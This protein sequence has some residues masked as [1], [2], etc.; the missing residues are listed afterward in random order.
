MKQENNLL[1]VSIIAVFFIVILQ[2]MT[3]LAELG[4]K[5]KLE[6][7]NK[8]V[9]ALQEKIESLHAQPADKA[10]PRPVATTPQPTEPT[11]WLNRGKS[12]VLSPDP[13]FQTLP[14]VK[15]RDQTLICRI[16]ADE[17]GF[18][19]I[20]ESSAEILNWHNYYVNDFLAH[21]H[22]EDP[23]KWAAHLA[24][25][26]KV[27]EDNRE[28]TIYLRRDVKWHKPQVD[29][30]DARYD[31]LKGDHYVTSHDFYFAYTTIINPQVQA[32]HLRPY[33]E[34]IESF[35]I[36]DDYTFTI[37]WKKSLYTNIS[38]TMEQFPLAKFL[39]A[40]D[41]NG[42][43]FNSSTFGLEFNRH[44]YNDGMMGCGPYIFVGQKAGQY[45]AL[46]RNEEYYGYKPV[47]QRLH[48]A[49]VTDDNTSYLKLKGQEI[50]VVPLLQENVY[51]DD[52]Y[53]GNASSPFKQGKLVEQVYPRL[54]YY[55]IDWNNA[56][57]IFR[58]K[59]VRRA[60]TYAFD[61]ERVLKN[62]CMG[63]GTI[64]PG[65]IP[66]N[67]L[68]YNKRITP[69]P[70]DLKVA[71]KILEDAGW[72][73]DNGDGILEKVI[74]GERRKFEF[75]LFYVGSIDIYRQM[76]GIYRDSLLKIGVRMNPQGADWPVIQQ[77]YGD[78]DFDAIHG[79]WSSDYPLDFYQIW[80][81]KF[82]D[83]A[84]SSN[85]IRFKNDEVDE[86]CQKMREAVD[87][88]E[89]IKLA[90]RMQEIWHDEQP[91]TFLFFR[92]GVAAYTNNVQNRFIRPL[93][94]HVLVHGYYFDVIK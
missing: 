63:L 4:N 38:Y 75:T 37:R 71:R 20:L 88:E 74:D 19:Y 90:H 33:Y 84:K 54:V 34:D 94:P 56:H 77:K 70:Y 10:T 80:H 89:R 11:R 30:S 85:R 12:F 86:I 87:I 76:Y 93:Y 21:R 48:F 60:M 5:R 92:S 9:V 91:Y 83:E 8:K 52:I 26:I 69:Y 46:L 1:G 57:P 49:I 29:W 43:E 24:E 42:N 22:W 39:F 51:R 65:G 81:S 67:S 6:D 58:D 23:D 28:F 2:L 7:I 66:P 61:R 47:L 72:R 15:N 44:W 36:H 32:S 82:A 17:K 45:V 18:N 3:Y 41:K 53:R 64:T 62:I 27:T 14:A 68:Y 13:Y 25:H 73:D 50:N 59:M 55:H 78:K 16:Q 31:W 35:E 40:K 79:V